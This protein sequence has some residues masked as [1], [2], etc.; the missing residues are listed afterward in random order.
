MNEALSRIDS[1]AR[2]WGDVYDD[3]MELLAAYD[4]LVEAVANGSTTLRTVGDITSGIE[5]LEVR[6]RIAWP[7]S[8]P[9]GMMRPYATDQPRRWR[10]RV[11]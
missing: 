10:Y 6:L 3:V 5:E 9:V 11:C 4:A 8:A 7:A 1:N 2:D